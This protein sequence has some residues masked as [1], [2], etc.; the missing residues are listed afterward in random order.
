MNINRNVSERT[1]AFLFFGSFVIV[2]VIL[3]V[4]TN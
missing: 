1:G 4:L 3:Y 2:L